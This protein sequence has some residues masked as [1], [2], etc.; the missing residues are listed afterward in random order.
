MVF[1]ITFSNISQ[2]DGNHSGK[3]VM[4]KNDNY[5]V[6]NFDINNKDKETHKIFV[7]N[8][9]FEKVFEQRIE[10]NIKDKY[11]DCNSIDIDDENGTVY[12]LGK[13]FE[14]KS[15]RTKKKGKANYHFELFKVDAKGLKNISF[16]HADKF[17]SS[18]EL[19]KTNNRLACVGFYGKKDES[20]INGACLFNLN[21]ESLKMETTKFNPF[22]ETF[23]TDKYGNSKRKK[24]KSK[25]K[26]L[27][28]IDFKSVFVLD[29]GD[30]NINAEEYSIT[31]HS[32]MTSGG[33][34]RTYTVYHFDDIISLKMN[35]DGDLLWARNIN[36]RQV[37]LANSSYTSIPVGDDSYF[38]I[39]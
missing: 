22:T 29:N 31:T 2:Y 38:F 15:R 18:L 14:N 4:S 13:S 30:I 17:I 12:F 10:K 24:K 39:N 3:V 7:Y 19:V 28:N 34:M 16:K 26:G 23:L 36:K 25:K 37:G 5:F 11:F 1:A 6:I 27:K 21:P 32:Q 9:N 8:N 20:K 35:K 33:G